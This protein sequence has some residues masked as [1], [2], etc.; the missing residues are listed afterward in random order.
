M[1]E[2]VFDYAGCH[3]GGTVAALVDAL[4]EHGVLVTD[5]GVRRP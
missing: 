4:R 5:D 1:P 2:S 3:T